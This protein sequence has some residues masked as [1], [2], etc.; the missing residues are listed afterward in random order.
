MEQ[1]ADYLRF[2]RMFLRFAVP[3][4]SPNGWRSSY[5]QQGNVVKRQE[6][7]AKAVDVSQN[8]RGH[9]FPRQ[10]KTALR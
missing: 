4:L 10:P 6:I 2:R 1:L 3:G 5:N 9:L 8:A 7:A